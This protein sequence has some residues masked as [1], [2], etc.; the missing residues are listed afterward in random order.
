MS[1]PPRSEYLSH[2]WAKDIFANR[3]LFI[4]G[5]AGTIGSAQTRAMVHL[6]ADACIVG[7]SVEK[8]E[9]AAREIAKVRPGARVLGL[10]GVD[11]RNFESVKAAAERCVK[12]LGAIDY[13]VAGA[14]GNFIAPLSGMSPNAFKTVIDIDTLGTFNTFKATIP[15][16]VESAKRNPNPNPSGS[17]GGRFISVS[18]T[19]HYTGMPLQAH[20]AAAKAAIDSL[21]G[22]VALEYGPFGVTANSIAPGAIEGTEGME[23]LASSKVSKRDRT[24]GVPLGRWGTVRDI[25]DATVFLFSDAGSYVNGTTLIVDGA[26]WRRQGGSLGVGLDPGMEYP[27]FLLQ[28]TFSKFVKD[29][30]KKDKVKL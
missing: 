21:M 14:A 19:F 18:A 12:E 22:S 1:V 28:G 2:V 7:R 9:A 29:G 3:V 23:R 30:R 15:Y 6:G 27:E 25:A 10:G 16:L 5:G 13:V 20:V 11:V 24:K 8:T 26:G 17:T 4:T